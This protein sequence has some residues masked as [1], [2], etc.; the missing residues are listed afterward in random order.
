MSIVVDRLVL[1]ISSGTESN[2]CTAAAAAVSVM[3]LMA[4]GYGVVVVVVVL[5]QSVN[6]ISSEA[7][8]D[9]S[10]H[11]TRLV[12]LFSCFGCCSYL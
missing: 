5:V 2:V 8:R 6:I 1:V 9:L 4:Y 7:S 10:E 11:L 3:V 12:S